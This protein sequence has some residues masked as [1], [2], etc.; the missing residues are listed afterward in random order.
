M[1]LPWYNM[2]KE[3]CEQ[4]RAFFSSRSLLFAWD[5]IRILSLPYSVI[6]YIFA[7]K[8]YRKILLP[9]CSV[10]FKPLALDLTV[11]S[12]DAVKTDNWRRASRGEHSPQDCCRHGGW[13]SPPSLALCATYTAGRQQ[14]GNKAEMMIH[15][16][17]KTKSRLT[18]Y[19]KRQGKDEK[20][21]TM[22]DAAD[23][24]GDEMRPTC[25]VLPVV[26]HSVA[27]QQCKE[28]CRYLNACKS[29]RFWAV[30]AHCT[31]I[32]CYHQTYSEAH[33]YKN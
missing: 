29:L 30:C 24:G 14:H 19:E 33:C 12:V 16:W 11:G 27:L 2:I 26:W 18:S 17:Q 8:C 9:C 28:T 32:C 13:A 15:F 3:G 21:I 6:H 4:G 22:S 20:E 25:T 23:L 5:A 7:I 31:R 10:Q 1:I